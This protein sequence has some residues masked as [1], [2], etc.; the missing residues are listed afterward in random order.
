LYPR[1]SFAAKAKKWQLW[2]KT[3]D[4]STELTVRR[5]Q[6]SFDSSPVYM[7]KKVETCIVDGLSERATCVLAWAKE[8]QHGCPIPDSVL[9]KEW[10]TPWAAGSDHIDVEVRGALMDK[11]ENF[12]PSQNIPT[13]KRLVDEHLCTTAPVGTPLTKLAALEVDEFNLL[14]KRL[15]YDKASWHLENEQYE[16]KKK[17]ETTM[18]NTK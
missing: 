9:H 18:N 13:L 16:L 10:I 11:S 2:L 8:V 17:K 12:V 7:R 5:V 14:M 3:T 1:F 4:E 6:N 15:E